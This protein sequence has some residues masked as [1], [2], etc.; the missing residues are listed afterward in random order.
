MGPTGVEMEA[1]TAVTVAA[2][3]LMMVFT[4]QHTQRREQAATQRK[5]DELLRAVPGAAASLMML[6]EAPKE[7]ILEVEDG[8]R[9]VRNETVEADQTDDEDEGEP[10][11]AQSEI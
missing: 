3:T 8:Q 1:L 7:T 2:L 5:L 4:I 6:E 9:E 10:P 11:E